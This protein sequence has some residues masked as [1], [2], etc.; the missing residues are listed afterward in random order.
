[1]HSSVEK[2]YVVSAMALNSEGKL[3]TRGP[4]LNLSRFRQNDALSARTEAAQICRVDKI[5]KNFSLLPRSTRGK[6]CGS[7]G[8]GGESLSR[9][10][11]H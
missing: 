3:A 1:M 5:V 9:R 7:G 8:G 4:M 10:E 6:V 11:Q 2:S